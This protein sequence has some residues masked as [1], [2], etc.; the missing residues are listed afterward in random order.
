MWFQQGQRTPNRASRHLS[1]LGLNS[2]SG[3]VYFVRNPA[4]LETALESISN[5]PDVDVSRFGFL[6]G[7]SQWTVKFP[8]DAGDVPLLLLNATGLIGTRLLA[9]VS[10]SVAG[11]TLGGSFQLYSG[12]GYSS[13]FPLSADEKYSGIKKYD[14][15]STERS[16]PLAWNSD[17]KDVRTA[18][19]LLLPSYASQGDQERVDEMGLD[20]VSRRGT[21]C[22]Y[23]RIR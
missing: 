15:T 18:F 2:L 10:E 14:R 19:A 8:S 6:N 9:S 17:A 13:G 11:A 4:Q 16:E 12:G 3:T 23:F 1:R 5:M 20:L 21:V 7:G 22:I